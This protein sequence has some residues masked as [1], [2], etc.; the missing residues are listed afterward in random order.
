MTL[1]QV[2]MYSPLAS[3]GSTTIG[4]ALDA[5]AVEVDADATSAGAGASSCAAAGAAEAALLSSCV[6]RTDM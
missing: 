4:D 6:V 5:S 3:T 2:S 1:P